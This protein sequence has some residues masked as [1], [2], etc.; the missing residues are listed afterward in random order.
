[1]ISFRVRESSL[2]NLYYV[3]I[4][5]DRFLVRSVM[6][7]H[8][9][10]S[11]GNR[12]V[13]GSVRHVFCFHLERYDK[14]IK[15]V[16]TSTFNR[17]M[18]NVKTWS[19]WNLS[20]NVRLRSIVKKWGLIKIETKYSCW[21]RIIKMSGKS[22]PDFQWTDDEI[23]LL[24]EATQNLKVEEDHKGL[25]W[26]AKRNKYDWIR[27]LIIENYPKAGDSEKYPNYDIVEAVI[28]KNRVSAKLKK[29]RAQFKKAVGCG[30]KSGGGFYFLYYLSKCLGK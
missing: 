17:F 8:K 26:E 7:Y 30:K 12:N 19:A 10:Q 5:S 27:A 3:S 11:N 20:K 16:Y 4:I 13:V 24:L 23:Q 1:M 15:F 2:N 9:L 25:N 22:Y 14:I 21:L 28:T 29:I 6:I 18:L